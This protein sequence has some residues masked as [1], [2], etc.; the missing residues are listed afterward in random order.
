MATKEINTPIADTKTKNG[1]VTPITSSNGGGNGSNSD[2][3]ADSIK[4]LGG[5]EAVRKRPAMYIGSTGELGLHHLVYEV[6]DNSVDEALAGFATKIEVTI[7][8]DNSITVIDDGRGIP[9]DDMVIDGEKVSA[10]QVVMTTLHAGGKFDSSTYKVSGGLH[11]VGVSCVNALSEDLELEIWRDGAT[12]QQNYSKG[13]PIGKLKKTG[14]T[15]KR[16]T[17]VHFVP[18]RS[19]FTATEYNYDTLAQRLRELA[20]LNKGL[21]I[22]LTDE[23]ATD[24]K[25][26]EPKQTDFKYNG[27]IAE[28]IK[29]LNR[30]KQV[31]HDK[32]IY[33]EDDRNGVHME[34]GLQYNDAYSESVFSFAN[35]INT[36][37]G[38]THLSGF[39][40][41]LTRTINYAGQQ[42][43]LFKDVKENLTGDDVR[44]G[45]VAVI[46]VKL[47]QPQFEGQ[48]KGKLNSDIAGT[49]TQF[50][51]ERLGAFFEQNATV[52]R[53]IIN[54]AVDAARAREAARK[55]RDLTRR[56]GALDSGGL[57]GKLADC[58][59]RDPNRC[60]LFLVEGE[61]AG[62]TAKQ[63]RDRRFQAILP[64][65]GKILNVE[66]ARYDKM[67]AHE[68]IRAMITAL[69][70]GISKEDFDP[71]KV[72][73]GKIIL[74]T[75]ADVDGSHIRTLL[76]TFFFRHMQELI[77]R[78]NV[79]IAQP[80]LFGIKKG[81]SHQYIK[82]E[83]EFVKVMVKRASEGLI[84]RYGEGAAKLEGTALTKFITVLNEYLGF[85][86][87]LNKRI[88]EERI[89]TL[90]PKLDLAKRADFEG[91]KQTPPKKIEKLEREL[92]RL[93]KDLK[94]K[95]V[96][97]RF[98]EEHN[99]WA[100]V[101]VNAQ[102]AEHIINWELASTPECRQLI[103][104]FKQIEQYLDPPFMIESV[105]KPAKTAAA[106]EEKDDEGE[107]ENL[108]A[109]E[110]EEAE[111][112]E[113]KSG[114]ALARRAKEPEIVEKNTA[115][116]LFDYVLNEG[117]KE[118]TV[119]RY[120]GLGE[121]TAEQ[122]WETTMDPE[123]RT[124]LQ[125]RL[126]DIAECETIFTTL[127]GE[128]VE[129]RRK[130]IE[131]NALDVKNL[132]I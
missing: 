78:S 53:K 4:V 73:Y 81:K 65:K 116:E 89:T 27:G 43:G 93:Q 109:T 114:K 46:S 79:Y 12:W 40:T 71:T 127:M 123:R 124:L 36:V 106:A 128:D 28:F 20:F 1:N 47:P 31:L 131:D 96:E 39:R 95:S 14:A 13:D 126:E 42:M 26:G 67:L 110:N 25:T 18:D 130:F 108:S 90:L 6:V 115:R 69:G 86:D 45:L 121:M 23:R 3:N 63:G 5:M 19:I 113:K 7:H 29:H 94:L 87:K 15:K 24:S 58:S 49:V 83:H 84:I 105:V 68:E 56:K 122:L 70:T 30:G 51:N 102:G 100:L 35:N 37:D 85:L 101:F 99:L 119:Q 38:G 117:R 118:Y 129:A 98:D 61:S 120:K 64:L 22:T 76:L 82:N 48:T 112:A 32:P 33:M 125:V 97:T 10:A 44:E 41:A 107:A 62:G 103:T 60:E 55:A 111:K 59:E 2:Y 91:D 77:K 132:D 88:R 54:K 34:I 104:K 57:P 9:V 16:G 75:D 11:G 52:G 92:K 21:L 66:K 17:K 72:R 74:M 50:V 8:L 80:P